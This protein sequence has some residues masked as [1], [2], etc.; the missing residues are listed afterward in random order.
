MSGEIQKPDF[1]A[2]S[3]GQK[4]SL[5]IA[6]YMIVKPVFNCIL[7]GGSLAPLV[8]GI[9]AVVVFYL[10]IKA[11]NLVIAILLM[12]VACANFPNN[13]RN[14]GLNSYLF[15]TLEGVLDMLCAVVL[16]FHPEI[17]TH[18]KLSK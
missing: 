16:A 15:Y 17:R 4:I 10:G 14:I 7:L 11:T 2:M 13:I 18:F 8:L 3:T 12:L 6:L 5:V 1:S 9:I